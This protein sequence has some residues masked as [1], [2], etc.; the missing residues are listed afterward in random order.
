MNTLINSHTPLKKLIKKA[1]NF[2]QKPGILKEIYN[3]I[4]KN[5]RFLK[6]KLNV[7]IVIKIFYIKNIKPIQTAYQLYEGELLLVHSH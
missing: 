1:K 7:L 3:V 6:G 2:Q 4:E 5:N